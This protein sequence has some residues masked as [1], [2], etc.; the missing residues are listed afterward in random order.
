VKFDLEGS[1]LEAVMS[2]W[3]VELMRFVWSRGEADS[4][5][6]WEYLQGTDYG[7]SRASVIFFLNDMV[8]EGFLDF[9]RETGK[10]GYHRVYVPV[11]GVSDEGGFRRRVAERVLARLSEF[12][13]EG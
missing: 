4:R 13:G 8:D 3:Q 2:P 7:M 9:R 11:S 1:G 6:G 12:Q 5:A 10:G